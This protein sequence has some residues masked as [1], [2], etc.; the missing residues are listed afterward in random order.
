MCVC[1]Y[2]SLCVERGFA[3]GQVGSTVGDC[4]YGRVVMTKLGEEDVVRDKTRK[5]HKNQRVE[6]LRFYSVGNGANHVSD[7]TIRKCPQVMEEMTRS[8]GCRLKY[9]LSIYLEQ[10]LP[11]AA[12][13]S[14]P[15]L[16]FKGCPS[17]LF[18][19]LRRQR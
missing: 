10:P 6:N 19:D 1:R 7:L 2:T 3:G 4:A 5:L 17:L 13:L 12:P 14:H 18:G 15:F 9:L 16:G 8:C 11:E